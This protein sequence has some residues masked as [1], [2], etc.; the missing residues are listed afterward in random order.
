MNK[1]LIILAAFL[2]VASSLT[3]CEE[4]QVYSE[5]RL[6]VEVTYVKLTSK[7]NSKVDLRDVETG[8]GFFEQRLSCSRQK[9][10]NVVVGS[11][12]DVTEI[13]YVYPESKRYTSELVG[14]KAICERSN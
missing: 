6:T 3:G 11:K 1:R 2:A 8:E 4:R 7:S 14:T 13:T 12:W 9:A 5:K 10:Q